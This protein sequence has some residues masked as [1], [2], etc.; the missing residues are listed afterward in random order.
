VTKLP[1]RIVFQTSGE[2]SMPQNQKVSLCPELLECVMHV[3]Q[4][5]G[6]VV[7]A[8]TRRPVSI[9]YLRLAEGIW[10]ADWLRVSV[11]QTV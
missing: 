10:F 6:S 5:S 4:A 11:P 3:P 7:N 9:L 1:G 2:R 8:V